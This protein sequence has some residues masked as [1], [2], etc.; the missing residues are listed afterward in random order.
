MNTYE[1]W[2]GYN[3]AGP[4]TV[5]CETLG[6]AA[7]EWLARW[8]SNGIWKVDGVFWPCFGDMDD[9]AI[10]VIDP[11]SER[12]LTRRQVLGGVRV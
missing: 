11:V 7:D 1:I 2:G 8:N 6:D 3:Y 4:I 5:T 10:A 9:E 12:Y